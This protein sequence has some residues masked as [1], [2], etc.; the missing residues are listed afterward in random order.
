MDA[1]GARLLA[2]RIR[3]GVSVGMRIELVQ[4]AAD[5]TGLRAGDRGVVHQ[6]DDRDRVFVAWDRGFES[7]I[8]PQSTRFHKLAA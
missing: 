8:D 1:Q 7:E 3:T 6:V 2:A 4:D 5:E